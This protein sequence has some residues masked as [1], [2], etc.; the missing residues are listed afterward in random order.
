L[1]D[2]QPGEYGLL[3]GLIGQ[4]M[5]MAEWFTQKDQRGFPVERASV[6]YFALSVLYVSGEWQW[7]V[8]HEG[9]NVA[10]G[11]ARG[12]LAARQQAEIAARRL[13]LG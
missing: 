9:R 5:K 6:G 1:N 10:E 11:A 2:A 12:S 3:F 13:I 7:L 8:Q 4:G